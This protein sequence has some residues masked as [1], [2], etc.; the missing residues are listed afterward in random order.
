MWTHGNA[1]VAS[2][3]CRRISSQ[4]PLRSLALPSDVVKRR[5]RGGRLPSQ[6]N[7]REPTFTNH[8]TIAV[9][10]VSGGVQNVLVRVL[11]LLREHDS[12]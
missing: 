7:R 9:G 5:S 2:Y 6:R 11:P 3:F 1:F 10:A 8:D 4:N 12:C